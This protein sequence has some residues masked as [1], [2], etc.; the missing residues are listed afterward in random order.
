MWLIHGH[1]TCRGKHRA[2]SASWI[3]NKNQLN[4]TIAFICVK[5]KINTIFSSH[6]ITPNFYFYSHSDIINNIILHCMLYGPFALL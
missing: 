6:I 1:L 4:N 2:G 3:S 5:C